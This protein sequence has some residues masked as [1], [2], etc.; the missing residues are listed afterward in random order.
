MRCFIPSAWVGFSYRRCA[1]TAAGVMA[2]GTALLLLAGAVASALGD[3]RSSHPLEVPLHEPRVVILKAKHQ[4][5]LFDGDRLVRSYAIDLGFNPVGQ[6]RL[7]GDGR[8]PEGRFRLVVKNSASQYHR[9]LG[10]DYPNSEAADFGLKHGLISS[11]EAASIYRAL[12]AGRCPEWGTALGGGVGIHG[13]RKGTD[14]TAGC[15]ALSDKNVEELF[16]VLRLG[17][18]IE[19]LP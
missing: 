14:W 19:I 12:E 1:R 17:D 11:G 4:L 18:S 2:C 6:K 15:V 13:R 10:I 5:H 8:T 9:F 7:A 3:S 16:R